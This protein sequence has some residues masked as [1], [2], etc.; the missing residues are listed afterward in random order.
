[1]GISGVEGKGKGLQ[2]ALSKDTLAKTKDVLT[3]CGQ[4]DNKCIN[5]VYNLLQGTE[6]QLDSKLERR[7]QIAYYW[8]E[9]HFGKVTSG[10]F[11]AATSYFL[12]A[13]WKAKWAEHDG[14]INFPSIIAAQAAAAATAKAVTVSAG[15]KAIATHTPPPPPP[16]PVAG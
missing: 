12:L 7:G 1:M 3:K 10:A 6:L 9:L 14:G 2:F 8:R 16:T 13:S 4:D 11:F 15:G 5:D